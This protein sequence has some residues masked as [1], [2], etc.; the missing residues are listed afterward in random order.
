M[1]KNHC[2]DLVKLALYDAIE[3]SKAI[4]E[5]LHSDQGSEYESIE[6]ENLLKALEIDISR[7]A[8]ASPWQNGYQE[9]FFSHFKLELG[10]PNR[11]QHAGELIEAIHKQI[12]YYN[13]DRIHSRLKTSPNQFFINYQ[14]SLKGL[15]IKANC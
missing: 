3:R 1:L 11:F 5:V 13:Q 14:Q 8:V 12:D 9:A 15:K 10:N 7:S 6:F 4:P 2:T